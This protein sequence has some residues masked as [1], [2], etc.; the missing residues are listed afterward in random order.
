MNQ[1]ETFSLASLILLSTLLAQEDAPLSTPLLALIGNPPADRRRAR[2]YHSLTPRPPPAVVL[3]Y[4]S[5]ALLVL[6]RA[7]LAFFAGDKNGLESCFHSGGAGNISFFRARPP[8]PVTMPRRDDGEEAPGPRA[9]SAAAARPEM[10]RPPALAAGSLPP[11]DAPLELTS[12]RPSLPR[13][14]PSGPEG[15]EHPGEHHALQHLHDSSS[16]PGTRMG[17]PG[18][19]TDDGEPATAERAPSVDHDTGRHGTTASLPPPSTAP[20]AEA[21]GSV[22]MVATGLA[23]DVAQLDHEAEADAVRSR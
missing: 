5:L 19:G 14:D 13:A 11:L 9:R 10:T 17:T 3:V 20:S 23:E 4:G 8:S 21:G 15:A 18:F 22:E 1:L 12:S 16:M 6:G 7:L 2:R